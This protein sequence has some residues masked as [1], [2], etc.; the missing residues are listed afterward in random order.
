MEIGQ[1]DHSHTTVRN[2]GAP[3]PAALAGP[4]ATVATPRSPRPTSSRPPPPEPANLPPP[5]LRAR[6]LQRR[7]PGQV[8]PSVST[9]RLDLL[10]AGAAPERARHR[11]PTPNPSPN[12]PPLPRLL[13]PPQHPVSSAVHTSLPPARTQEAEGDKTGILDKTA[14]L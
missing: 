3:P 13:P 8:V 6:R 9:E 11:R 2:A 4:V 7:R 1:P 14:I 10:R 5:L 12:H